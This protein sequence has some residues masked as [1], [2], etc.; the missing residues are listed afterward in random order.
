MLQANF[1]R[2]S[3]TKGPSPNCRFEGRVRSLIAKCHEQKKPNSSEFGFS[4]KTV[5]KD[6]N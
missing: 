5:C 3:K 6:R 4:I 2:Y 1:L